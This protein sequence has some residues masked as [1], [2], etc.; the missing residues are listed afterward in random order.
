MKGFSSTG[1]LGAPRE[2]D[3]SLMIL[4]WSR[5]CA[6]LSRPQAQL[7]QLAKGVWLSSIRTLSSAAPAPAEDKPKQGFVDG[8]FSVCDFPQERVR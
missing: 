5:L 8:G 7:E 1:V 6:H 3:G 4:R 2:G